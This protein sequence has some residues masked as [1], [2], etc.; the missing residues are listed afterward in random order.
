MLHYGKNNIQSVECFKLAIIYLLCSSHDYL[1]RHLTCIPKYEN[2]SSECPMLGFSLFSQAWFTSFPGNC[3]D[4]SLDQYLT[5][6]GKK[7]KKKW[8]T[9]NWARN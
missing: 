1:N 5:S 3:I 4:V 8:G 2:E 6:R 9:Q 7:K